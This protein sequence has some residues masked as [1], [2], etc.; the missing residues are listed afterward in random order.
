MKKYYTN[1]VRSNATIQFEQNSKT[2]ESGVYSQSQNNVTL[3]YAN[4]K[5]N[6]FGFEVWHKSAWGNPVFSTKSKETAES[7]SKLIQQGVINPRL[8]IS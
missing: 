7:L 8:Q 1:K 5:K 2:R 3:S 4:G 6:I